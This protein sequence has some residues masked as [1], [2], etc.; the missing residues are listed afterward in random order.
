MTKFY[1]T[2]A[3]LELGKEAFSEPFV[4]SH[5]TLLEL[6]DIKSS[7][8]KDEEV[9]YKARIVCHLL[10]ENT[11]EYKVCNYG[12]NAISQQLDSLGLKETPDSIICAEAT[13][14]TNE[15]Y[16][17]DEGVVFVTNDIACKNIAKNLFLLDVES[18]SKKTE[19]TYKG[20]IEI[21]TDDK[22]L[23]SVYEHPAENVYNLLANE[24]LI[25]KD[26]NGIPVD[27]LKWTGSEYQKVKYLSFKSDMF[28]NVKPYNND[29]YQALAMDS[30]T[31]NK[32]TMIK[33]TAAT[34]KSYLSIGYLMS[35]MDK[36]KID[37][38]IVFCN[39]VATANAAKLGFLPG[40]QWE[41]L[42]DASI[43]NMLSA[44]FGSKDYVTHMITEEKL[45]LL[46]MCDVRGF[47]TTGMNCGVYITEAQNMDISLMKLAVQRIGEDSVCTIIDGDYNT[48][49]DSNQYSGS[50]NGMHR[51]SEVFRGEDIYGEV[52]LQN[53]YRS[54]IAAIAEKM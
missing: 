34:G 54:R 37:K 51:L 12:V 1:D 3:L 24:Y 16:D 7:G 26:E 21:N 43:G 23:S 42:V 48:Q 25:V 8:K 32:I 14:Y 47:D 17:H 49:V 13:L 53:I 4:I 29:V 9:K 41:K 15:V 5:E 35:L 46:P 30:L 33:G 6:E 45:R 20:F 50:K 2:N 36:H 39:T 19:D 10:D 40:E 38:I 44:K 27:E 18:V 31:S 11:D 22:L 28:K 52:E